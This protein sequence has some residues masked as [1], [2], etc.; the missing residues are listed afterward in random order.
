MPRWY[1]SLACLPLFAASFAAQAQVRAW[2]DRDQ[3]ALGETLTLNVQTTEAVARAADWSPLE[4]DFSVSGN[5]SSRQGES[6]N[7]PI[8]RRMPFVDALQHRREGLLTVPAL[9][10]G[11]QGTQPLSLTVT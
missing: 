11:G 3:V 8:S 1:T 4:K 9:N 5:S 2:I 6:G 10:G 7:G